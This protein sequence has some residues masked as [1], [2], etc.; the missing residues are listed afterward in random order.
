MIAIFSTKERCIVC[1]M[2]TR[3]CEVGIDV[4]KFAIKGTILDNT[5]SSCIGCGICISVCP[6]ATLSFDEEFGKGPLVK[7]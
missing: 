6:T 5:N 1:N 7:Q 2:C 3:Y 4:R